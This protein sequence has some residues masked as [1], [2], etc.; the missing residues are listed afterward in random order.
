MALNLAAPTQ[1]TPESG[2]ATATSNS[3]P[4]VPPLDAIAAAFP[5]LEIEGL[6]GRGG[7]GAVFK[8]RQPRLNRFVALKILPEK[9]AS[10]PAFAARFAREG[11]LL[12]RLA[13][14]NIVAVHDFGQA[15]GF[16]YLIMEYVDG[17]NLRQALQAGR[18]TPAQALAIVPKICDAL[19]Y[20]HDE[21]VLHRDIKPENILLDQKG[22]VKL[23]DF[24]I[25]KLA[26]S[27]PD[28]NENPPG[29]AASVAAEASLTGSAD[30]L[31]TPHYMAPEQ[32][33][34]GVEVDHRADI[35][36]LGV[37]FYELLTGELPSTVLV[38]P[39]QRS[40]I[41]PRVD[42]VV[43]RA[44]ATP[45]T[46]RFQSAAE[47]KTELDEITR[48]VPPVSSPPH[49]VESTRMSRRTVALVSVALTLLLAILAAIPISIHLRRNAQQLLKQARYAEEQARLANSH[50]E[51][52]A[53]PRVESPVAKTQNEAF[54]LRMIA[55]SPHHN[56]ALA[57]TESEAGEPIH[58][59]TVHFTG[60]PFDEQQWQAARSRIAGPMLYPAET[61][62]PDSP[63]D[64]IL[65]Y[66][67]T[68]RPDKPG[69]TWFEAPGECQLQFAFPSD[70]DARDASLQMN[71][72][73]KA[74]VTLA[75]GTR[76]TL[77]KVGP[78]TGWLEARHYPTPPPYS[79]RRS[80]SRSPAYGKGGLSNGLEVALIT[81]PPNVDLTIKATLSRADEV[82]VRTLKEIVVRNTSGK[83]GLYWVDWY[84]LPSEN[85]FHQTPKPAWALH[86]HDARTTVEL[87]SI[88]S[89]DPDQSAVTRLP[90]GFGW[91][92]SQVSDLDG[93]PDKPIEL[94][95]LLMGRSLSVPGDPWVGVTFTSRQRG[96]PVTK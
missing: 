50:A 58:Q 34:R 73:L 23:A 5:Q 86:V 13:H 82:G 85:F 90:E 62:S 61:E 52:A 36:S 18:F 3:P 88:R 96:A 33:E 79:V 16:F 64:N 40:S 28:E 66:D 20:A 60:P 77:F 51:G 26:T 12:A 55:G 92:R 7:M 37:V 63:V 87:L 76:F 29:S 39:S 14:P 6:V 78:W 91:V 45:A 46:D 49:L 24:G 56:L 70:A 67:A 1:F 32:R 89:D 43:R 69:S 9:L 41:D 74:P 30:R 83:P 31:G 47:F 59:V 25:A 72:A 27:G 94:N 65:L 42:D 71:E 11:Q 54:V 44:L 81:L 84:T 93:T 4:P 95:G 19:Q 10:Q 21:G 2:D 80:R 53:A 35:Y 15:G 75:S 57:R 17:V 48:T 22:R 38:P 68:K 8:A